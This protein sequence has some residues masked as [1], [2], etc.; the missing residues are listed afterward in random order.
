MR[1]T[2]SLEPQKERNCNSNNY[3]LQPWY[4]EYHLLMQTCCTLK[5]TGY[6]SRRPHLVH[7]LSPKNR[8]QRLRLT[9]TRWSDEFQN[10]V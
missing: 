7:L 5:M 4:A 10:L 1:M 2:M 3:A 6:I 9:Q 8:K